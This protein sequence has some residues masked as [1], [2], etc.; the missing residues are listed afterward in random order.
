MKCCWCGHEC[1][2]RDHLFEWCKRW[3]REKKRVWVEGQE[4]EEGYDDVEK[5]MKKPKVRLPM[6]LVFAEEICSKAVLDFRYHTNVGRI[7]GEV[8]E[9]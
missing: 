2:T 9:A 3:K 5:V 4:G 1:Q 8:E 6:S 7:C